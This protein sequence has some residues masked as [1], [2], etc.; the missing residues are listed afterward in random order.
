MY[1][2]P[3]YRKWTSTIANNPKVTDKDI[4]MQPG[5]ALNKEHIYLFLQTHPNDIH[6]FSEADKKLFNYNYLGEL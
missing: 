2:S 6:Y 3:V 4:L 5:D 1:H